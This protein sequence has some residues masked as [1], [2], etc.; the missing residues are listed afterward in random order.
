VEF[1][2]RLRNL[3]KRLEEV[4]PRTFVKFA[5]YADGSGHIELIPYNPDLPKKNICLWDNIKHM[6]DEIVRVE[7]KYNVNQS[8]Y[9]C[10]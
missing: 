8:T 1:L 10:V 9:P 7:D 2:A 5:V 4:Y 6:I 3:Q